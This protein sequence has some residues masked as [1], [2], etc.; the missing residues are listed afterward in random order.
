MHSTS[1]LLLNVT[2]LEKIVNSIETIQNHESEAYVRDR[3]LGGRNLDLDEDSIPQILNH[4]DSFAS[5]SR[6]LQ[7]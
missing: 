7:K 1:S 3:F 4:I 2:S 6:A 5:Q